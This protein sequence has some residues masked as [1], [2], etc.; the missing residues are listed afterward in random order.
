MAALTL[1]TSIP[2]GLN[3][4]VANPCKLHFFSV[5]Q[6]FLIFL[7]LSIFVFYFYYAWGMRYSDSENFEV[8]VGGDTTTTTRQLGHEHII[9]WGDFGGFLSNSN[10]MEGKQ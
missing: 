5:E 6:F 4:N 10:Q 1:N 8:R 9:S 7:R 2:N 3:N